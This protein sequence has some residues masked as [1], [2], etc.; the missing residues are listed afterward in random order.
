M[1]NKIQFKNILAIFLMIVCFSNILRAQPEE[2]ED[3]IYLKNGTI[4]H[5]TIIEQ[6]LNVSTTIETEDG[7]VFIF[8]ADEIG[9]I[10]RRQLKT[11]K[12][13]PKNKIG[14][15]IRDAREL[16]RKD[17]SGKQWGWYLSSC[18]FPPNIVLACYLPPSN[19]PKEKLIYTSSD[20]VNS[21]TEC[22]RDRIKKERIRDAIDGG[23]LGSIIIITVC[24]ITSTN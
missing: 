2:M 4:L 20:F 13:I 5:G 10:I 15:A 21:Y 12:T 7:K 8:K 18:I 9:E 14:D 24:I 17:T 3:I 23:L 19:P 1:R 16:A 6:I 22:Y 11:D